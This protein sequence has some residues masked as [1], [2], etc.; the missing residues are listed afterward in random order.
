MSNPN[1][2]VSAA[3][4][5]H[6]R[7]RAILL[8]TSRYGCVGVS[9]LAADTGLAKSTISQLVCGRTRPLYSTAQ[10]IVKCLEMEAGRPLDLR[11]VFSETGAY[12]TAYVCDLFSCRC[13]PETIYLPDNTVGPPFV[14]VQRGEWTGDVQEFNQG[15]EQ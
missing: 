2:S 12:P 15:G 9:R 13:L 11:D 8:H 14:G 10:R 6:N 1:R 3:P 7:L 4:T 5:I